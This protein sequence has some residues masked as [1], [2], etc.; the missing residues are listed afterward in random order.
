MRHAPAGLGDDLRSRRA[1]VREGVVRIVELVEKI[2][3]AALLH[4]LCKI[5]G[6]FHALFLA[7]ENEFSAVSLDGR[8]AL[9]RQILRKDD[10]HAVALERRDHRKRNARI[11]ARCFNEDVAGLDVAPL[12]GL[13]NHGAGR[14]VLH[15]PCRV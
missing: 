13:F 5:A 15:G 8:A 11:A 6:A 10:L 3:F 12:L 14:A 2:A 7:H 4:C 1:E 9:E